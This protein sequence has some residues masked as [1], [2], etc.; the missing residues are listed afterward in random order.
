[1]DVSVYEHEEFM[2][3]LNQ[4]MRSS[5]RRFVDVYMYAPGKFP[6]AVIDDEIDGFGETIREEDEL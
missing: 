2:R 4:V 1:M 3:V 5:E 6:M